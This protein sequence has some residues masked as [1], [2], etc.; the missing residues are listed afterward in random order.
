MMVFCRTMFEGTS[1]LT[2]AQGFMLAE[3]SLPVLA[4]D[5]EPPKKHDVSFDLVRS[6]YHSAIFEDL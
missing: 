4:D 1:R 2:R 5:P 3:P 6:I